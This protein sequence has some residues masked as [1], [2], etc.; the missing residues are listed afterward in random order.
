VQ[1]GERST[2]PGQA[3]GGGLHVGSSALLSH[4]T[5]GGKLRNSQNKAQDFTELRWETGSSRR[6]DIAERL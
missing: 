5:K 2:R 3:G 6:G 4:I 1:G